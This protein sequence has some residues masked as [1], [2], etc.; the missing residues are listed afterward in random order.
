ME[1]IIDFCT[2]EM[3]T[4]RNDAEDEVKSHSKEKK[5]IANG[6]GGFGFHTR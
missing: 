4:R 2:A 5:S 6:I 3:K 1:I